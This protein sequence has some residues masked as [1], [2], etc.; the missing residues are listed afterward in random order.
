VHGE[1]P[2]RSPDDNHSKPSGQRSSLVRYFV[3]TVCF[4][5]ATWFLVI[6]GWFI[7][8]YFGGNL[9]GRKSPLDILMSIVWSLVFSV[10]CFAT[11]LGFLRQ[12][13]QLMATGLLIVANCAILSAFTDVAVT[14]SK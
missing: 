13:R 9:G 14:Y 5:G 4:V 11:G 3:A 8:D 7:R 12:M 1:H 2:Y 6:C 10:G